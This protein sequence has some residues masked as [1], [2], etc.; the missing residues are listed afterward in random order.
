[1]KTLDASWRLPDVNPSDLAYGGL[2]LPG[3]VGGVVTANHRT[4]AYEGATTTLTFAFEGQIVT[5]T[6]VPV[7]SQESTLGTADAGVLTLLA[8][9]RP[10]TVRQLLIAV[11]GANFDVRA[12]AREFG[13]DTVEVEG[14]GGRSTAGWVDVVLTMPDE[15][16]YRVT[17]EV[18]RNSGEAGIVYLAHARERIIDEA[19]L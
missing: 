18:R 4:Y 14:L 12:R 3:N 7:T 6:Y 17:V 1:M 2:I 15:A 11:F 8:A 13:G 19:D 16:H 5:S 10:G 9:E